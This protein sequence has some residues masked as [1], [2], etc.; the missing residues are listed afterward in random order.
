M[1]ETFANQPP[2][3]RV[4][5]LADPTIK[6]AICHAPLLTAPIG[7]TAG[8]CPG[9]SC[10]QPDVLTPGRIRDFGLVGAMIVSGKMLVELEEGTG[11]YWLEQAPLKPAQPRVR[12]QDNGK[13]FPNLDWIGPE[14]VQEELDR[15]AGF[16]VSDGAGHETLT[17]DDYNNE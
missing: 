5:P 6:C 7:K 10:L 17:R 8:L 12:L 16:T 3:Y 1:T 4:T 15:R 11:I 13:P 9:L 14:A 2:P